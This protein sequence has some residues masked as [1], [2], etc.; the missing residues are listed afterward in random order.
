MYLLTSYSK[1][2]FL[3]N[4]AGLPPQILFSGMYFIVPLCNEPTCQLWNSF[5]EYFECQA[6]A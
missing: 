6:L 2:R 3:M 1:S 5:P 4:L